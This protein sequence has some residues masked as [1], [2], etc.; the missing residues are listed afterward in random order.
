[1]LLR[2]LYD[3]ATTRHLLDDLA[4]APKSIRWVI[5]L[6]AAGRLLGPGPLETLEDGTRGKIF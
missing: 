6:D 3:L 5:P 1:M 2:H 4:F